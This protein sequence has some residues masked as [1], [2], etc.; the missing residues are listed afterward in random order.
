MNCFS[1]KKVYRSVADENWL[2]EILI[3]GQKFLAIKPLVH[4]FYSSECQDKIDYYVYYL[5]IDRFRLRAP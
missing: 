5:Q 1:V 3:F 2:P 4:F